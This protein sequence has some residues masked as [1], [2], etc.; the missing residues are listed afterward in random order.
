[1][2]AWL[3]PPITKTAERWVEIHVWNRLLNLTNCVVL[4]KHSLTITNQLKITKLL[5]SMLIFTPRLSLW[6]RLIGPKPTEWCYEIAELDAQCRELLNLS[7]IVESE[8]WRIGWMRVIITFKIWIKSIP[9][10]W[11]FLVLLRQQVSSLRELFHF[12][13]VLHPEFTSPNQDT[14]FAE[15]VLVSIH[16]SFLR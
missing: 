16:P 1:M 11:R 2:G 15:C 12:L 3:M 5:W 6:V 7:P 14:T 13:Q 8:N 4:L 9:I 10:G